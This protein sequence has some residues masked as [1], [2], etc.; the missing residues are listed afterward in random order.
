MLI[1]KPKLRIAIDLAYAQPNDAKACSYAKRLLKNLGEI[2]PAHEYIVIGSKEIFRDI[3]PPLANTRHVEIS[4]TFVSSPIGS[5]L[6][7]IRIAARGAFLFLFPFN[8]FDRLRKIY[9]S[10]YIS[11]KL[12]APF[13]MK[14]INAQLLFC[15]FLDS[16]FHSPDA[17]VVSVIDDLQYLAYPQFF[18]AQEISK[19][20]R[21]FR[22]TCRYVSRII[23]PSEFMRKV[24]L[25]NSNLKAEQVITVYTRGVDEI[26]NS[27]EGSEDLLKRLGVQASRYLL[28]PANYLP[29]KNH[30]ML[31]VGFNLYIQRHNKN[32]LKIVLTG[33]PDDRQQFLKEIVRRMGLSKQ[34]I[35]AEYLLKDDFAL[36][37]QKC[38][39]VII[40]SLYEGSGESLLEAMSMSKPILCSNVTALPEIARDSALYFDPRKPDDIAN[41]I[42]RLVNDSALA[43]DLVERGK[44]RLRELGDGRI[45]AKEYLQVFED[46]LSAL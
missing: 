17:P 39:A 8:V 29:H 2:A 13:T 16:L 22:D 40:P 23:A 26:G 1:A 5:V 41:A 14:D 30:E 27:V 19:R 35:F 25:A 36:L 46:V 37:M 9:R 10:T 20:D 42:S 31:F 11:T 28:Y 34:I 15:P 45:T 6:D 32:D 38:Y 21:A 4:D 12:L 7:R 3:S 44:L 43:D 24:I 18:T 33:L